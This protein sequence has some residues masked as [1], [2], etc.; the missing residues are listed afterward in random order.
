MTVR[1]PAQASPPID[2]ALA[3][4]PRL[5]GP[6]FWI[7]IV[8]GLLC[9]L[10]GAGVVFLGPKLF[11]AKPAPAA[12]APS[13]AP[14]QPSLD[15]RLADI[16][17]KLDARQTAEAP[18]A[19]P[20]AAGEVKALEDRVANLEAD[21]RRVTFAAAAALAAASLT[22]AAAG[23]HPFAGE[24]TALEGSLPASEDL[25]GLRPLADTGA[26][27]PAALAASYP[28]AAARAAVASRAH[29]GGNGLMARIA[30]AFAAIVT[31]RRVDRLEGDGVDA[32]LARAGKRIEDGDVSGALQ[33]LKALPPAGR[34]AMTDWRT[35]AERRVEI[36]RRIAA[37]RGAALSELTRAVRETA[38]S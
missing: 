29:T 10:G 22:E 36:D 25:R 1:H 8:F 14:V 13:A 30:R 7:A 28:D 16:Q 26:P 6:V 23:S 19:A 24:L 20:P 18:P 31:V 34:Q 15:Q 32:V 9:I 37:V 3:P 17:A 33:E 11:P 27:T 21:R 12:S 35:G 2:P 5:F 4:P 38:A